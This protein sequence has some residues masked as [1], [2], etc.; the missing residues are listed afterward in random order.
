MSLKCTHIVAKVCIVLNIRRR[1]RMY[2]FKLLYHKRIVNQPIVQTSYFDRIE[3]K[4]DRNR[5]RQ[6]PKK[7]MKRGMKGTI[8]NKWT[9]ETFA[10][11]STYRTHFFLPFH[12]HSISKTIIINRITWQIYNFHYCCRATVLSLQ[13]FSV[14]IIIF[15]IQKNCGKCSICSQVVSTIS[16]FFTFNSNS[17][18]R[19][20]L[21]L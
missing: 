14:F 18:D 21:K 12:C 16:A 13:V 7:R 19:N 2:A 8:W 6:T 5:G 1:T 9:D 10:H 11:W 17:F 3:R 20:S 15:F 4:R